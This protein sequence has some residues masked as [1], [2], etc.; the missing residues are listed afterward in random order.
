MRQSTRATSSS[1]SSSPH[2]VERSSRK[3]SPA[4]AA[5]SSGTSSCRVLTKLCSSISAFDDGPGHPA[6]GKLSF[7]KWIGAFAELDGDPLHLGH[8]FDGPAAAFAAHARVLDAAERHIG[9]VVD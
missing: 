6:R 9:F 7:S 3:K 4:K 2:G 8:F 1:I 5:L